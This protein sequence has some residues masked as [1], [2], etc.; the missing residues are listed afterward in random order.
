VSRRH[1]RE[2]SWSTAVSVLNAISA[3]AAILTLSAFFSLTQ[4]GWYALVFRLVTTP[5][6]ALT[7]A[8]AHSFWSEAAALARDERWRELESLYRR[9]TKH[10]GYAAIPVASVCLAGPLFVGP[11]LGKEWTGAGHVLTA[12][13][14]WIV[15]SIMFSATNHLVVMGRQRDQLFADLVRV[16]LSVAGIAAAHLLG[17]GFVTA[18]WLASFGSLTGHVALF[19]LHRKAHKSHV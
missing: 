11:L 12:C 10:L 1:F 6:G 7:N 4:V 13:T 19:I 8:L 16:V 17:L 15:G 5:V 18:V 3:N 9:T 2:A 14:P